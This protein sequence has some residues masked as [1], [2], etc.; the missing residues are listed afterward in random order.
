MRMCS[1]KPPT[2]LPKLPATA[3]LPTYLPIPWKDDTSTQHANE[4]NM[5]SSVGE[6]YGS[7][8]EV[9]ILYLATVLPQNRHK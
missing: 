8:E 7:P 1:T 6:M 2:L 3:Y 5:I 4:Q 9:V